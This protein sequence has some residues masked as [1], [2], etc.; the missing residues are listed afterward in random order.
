MMQPLMHYHKIEGPILEAKF[1]RVL[2]APPIR[3]ELISPHPRIQIGDRDLA[4]SQSIKSI[5]VDS[6][7]ADD[8]HLA[9]QAQPPIPQELT[10]RLRIKII[11]QP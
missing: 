5:A 4:K 7:T 11:H 8:E 6:P 3:S 2:H 9:I 1:L 10:K